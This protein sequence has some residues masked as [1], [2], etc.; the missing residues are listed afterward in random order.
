MARVRGLSP[1]RLKALLGSWVAAQASDGTDRVFMEVR[2]I[3]SARMFLLQSPG[4]P[5]SRRLGQGTDNSVQSGRS[6]AV[7]KRA[8]KQLLW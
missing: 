4:E 6:D 8:V 7:S 1:Q 2:A 3:H 5:T